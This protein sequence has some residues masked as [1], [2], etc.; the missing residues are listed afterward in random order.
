MSNITYI[1]NFEYIHCPDCQKGILFLL[2]SARFKCDTCS[3]IYPVT[4]INHDTIMRDD[5]VE[6]PVVI[7]NQR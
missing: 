4:G 2:G 5:G 6:Y 3:Q 7:K 1:P